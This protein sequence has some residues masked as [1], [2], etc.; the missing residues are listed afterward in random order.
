M[1]AGSPAQPVLDALRRR[2]RSEPGD[3][4]SL[5][6]EKLQR[7]HFRYT[8]RDA[9]NL[10]DVRNLCLGNVQSKHFRY[11][12]RDAGVLADPGVVNLKSGMKIKPAHDEY[13]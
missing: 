7:Q 8:F 9:E 10:A 2:E 6:P 4:D 3:L 13:V 12:F 11:T 5:G 1:D